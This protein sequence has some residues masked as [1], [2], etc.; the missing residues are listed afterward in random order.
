M[1][2]TRKQLP[3]ARLWPGPTL[4]PDLGAAEAELWMFLRCRYQP[5]NLAISPL[6]WKAWPLLLVVAAFNPENIGES[7]PHR[8]LAGRW[9][10]HLDP[11][12]GLAGAWA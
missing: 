3:T 4:L 8:S 1:S 11:E 12:W 9:H 10:R 7:W 2:R 5:P 6:Y